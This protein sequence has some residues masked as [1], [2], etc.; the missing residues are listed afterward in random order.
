MCRL[1]A[2]QTQSGDRGDFDEE[3][4]MMVQIEKRNNLNSRKIFLASEMKERSVG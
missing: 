4:W 3:N 2:K 1:V